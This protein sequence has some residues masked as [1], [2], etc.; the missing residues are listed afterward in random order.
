MVTHAYFGEHQF[1]PYLNLAIDEVLL[2][3]TKPG[4][5]F[6]RFYS[7][8]CPVMILAY[9]QSPTD[10]KTD[11]LRNEKIAVARRLSPG[12]VM[13]CDRNSLCYSIIGKKSDLPSPS[14]ID[15]IHV[16]HGGK[17]ADVLSEN[18]G[19]PIYVGK[20][21]SLRTSNGIDTI[22]SGNGSKQTADSYLYHGIIAIKP[23]DLD[24]LNNGIVLSERERQ[25]IPRL[26][27]IKR[28][29]SSLVGVLLQG[30]TNGKYESIHQHEYEQILTAAEKL[31]REKY[32]NDKWV[33]EARLHE[34]ER[35]V[36]LQN[37]SG[38]C[39][40]VTWGEEEFLVTR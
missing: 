9:S 29:R 7:F 10:L 33:Y 38:F 15:D 6:V 11:Y 36:V 28:E 2:Q 3:R 19:S 13:Y 31:A 27:Y 12:G 1:D 37:E 39:F 34:E 40:C 22:V 14:K 35:D 24:F 30:L 26:P 32:S 4:V 20:H 23:W 5:V 8:S 21:F 17:I 18:I 16:I 25:I